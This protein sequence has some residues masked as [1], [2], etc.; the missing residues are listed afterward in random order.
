MVYEEEINQNEVVDPTTMIGYN[1]LLK[2]KSE[3]IDRPNYL[4]KLDKNDNKAITFQKVW[5]CK[6][7]L[8]SRNNNVRSQ[9]LK[10]LCLSFALHRLL[11]RRFAGYELA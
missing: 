6:G 4:T 5:Q 7:R 11:L 10:D 3:N 8:L 9:R 2:G 1:Y